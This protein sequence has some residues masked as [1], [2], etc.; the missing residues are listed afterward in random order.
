M[1]ILDEDLDITVNQVSTLE[2]MVLTYIKENIPKLQNIN[3]DFHTIGRGKNFLTD[4]CVLIYDDYA[5][6]HDEP[7][8]S[9]KFVNPKLFGFESTFIKFLRVNTN[10]GIYQRITWKLIKQYFNID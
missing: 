6:R 7:F 5:L 4:D 3:F 10:P 1:S 9:I 8:V 2:N